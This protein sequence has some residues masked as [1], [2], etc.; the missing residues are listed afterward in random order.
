MENIIEYIGKVLIN[1]NSNQYTLYKFISDIFY[2]IIIARKRSGDVR[3][4]GIMVLDV[5]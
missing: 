3:A 2:V 4:V 1:L 5:T